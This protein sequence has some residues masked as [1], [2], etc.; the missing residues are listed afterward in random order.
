MIILDIIYLGQEQV[1]LGL[2]HVAD[3]VEI[4]ISVTVPLNSNES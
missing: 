3:E 4:V 2:I 1:K